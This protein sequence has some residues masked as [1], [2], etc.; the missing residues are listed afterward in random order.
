MATEKNH[1]L[2]LW[3]KEHGLSMQALA[4]KVECAQSFISQIEAWKRQPS[5]KTAAKFRRETGLPIE[6]FARES[7][8]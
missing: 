6:A 8:Q 1:P 2:T 7:V 5:L 4:E 3:R